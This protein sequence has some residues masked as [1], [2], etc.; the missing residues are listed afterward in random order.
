MV[1]GKEGVVKFIGQ[2]L[3]DRRLTLAQYD[4]LLA[5]K[6]ID[7]PAVYAQVI[8]VRG[9]EEVTV[10]LSTDTALYAPL[11]TILLPVKES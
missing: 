5:A 4:A 1:Y 3:I 2:L 9:R 7:D 11:S 10:M 6:F 8:Q